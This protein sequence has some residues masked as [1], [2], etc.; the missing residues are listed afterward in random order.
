[1]ERHRRLVD[2][3]MASHLNG[4]PPGGDAI[5]GV[6]EQPTNGRLY[7]GRAITAPAQCS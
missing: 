3:D 2:G 5:A 7:R 1:M 4:A 6:P